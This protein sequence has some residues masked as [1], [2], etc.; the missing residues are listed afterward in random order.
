[1]MTVCTGPGPRASLP[2]VARR[3]MACLGACLITAAVLLLASLAV[4]Q[5]W[6][7]TWAFAINDSGQI[8]GQGQING[9]THAYLLT[10]Q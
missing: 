6:T 4:A 5:P 2:R 1:M 3:S 9:Q 8:T 10:P 7:L